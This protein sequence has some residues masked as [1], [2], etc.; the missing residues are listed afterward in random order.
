LKQVY[1]RT[2]AVSPWPVVVP[3]PA[4]RWTQPFISPYPSTA[5]DTASLNNLQCKATIHD[6]RRS[7]RHCLLAWLTIWALGQVTD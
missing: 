1:T 2:V 6:L 3:D 4:P 7:W 5:V